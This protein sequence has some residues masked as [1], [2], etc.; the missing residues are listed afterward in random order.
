MIILTGA[1]GGI[2]KSIVSDLSKI[3]NVIGIYHKNK[4]INIDKKVTYEKV[5]INDHDSIREFID[6]YSDI[7]S[8]ITVIHCAAIKIDG[9]ALTYERSDWDS[10]ILT[11]LT[12]DFMLTQSL[13]P[14]MMKDKMGRIIHF[15]SKGGIDGEQGTLAYSVSKHGVIGLSRVLSKEY[16]KFNITSNVLVL[17]AFGVGMYN[18]LHDDIKKNIIDKTPSKKIGNTSNIVNAIKFLIHSDYVNGSTINI[19]GGM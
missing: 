13:L 9:I 17:G 4:P 10:T 12:S 6:K 19:D 2:G 7:F 18:E 3:D 14:F 16:A 5:D 15:S 8:N 11:N 1:T